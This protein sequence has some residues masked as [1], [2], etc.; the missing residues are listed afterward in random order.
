[1]KTRLITTRVVLPR[2]L[3]EK[4]GRKARKNKVSVSSYILGLVFAD[5]NRGGKQPQRE[6]G[7]SAA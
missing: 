2:I 1:M 5:I 6:R 7:D 3:L 4:L